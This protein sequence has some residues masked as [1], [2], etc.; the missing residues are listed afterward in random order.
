MCNNSL[1]VCKACFHAVLIKRDIT[2]DAET[3]DLIVA[4]SGAT[5]LDIRNFVDKVT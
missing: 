3:M 5:S 2:Y 1:T 4:K